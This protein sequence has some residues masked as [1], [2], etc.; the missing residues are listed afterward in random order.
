MRKIIAFI[1]LMSFYSFAF[2]QAPDVIDMKKFTINGISKNSS[3]NDLVTIFGKPDSIFDPKYDCGPLS[4]HW[5][6]VEVY[7]YS[8][9]NIE[10]HIIN[11]RIEFKEIELEKS[12]IQFEIKIEDISINQNST[13]SDLK[14]YFPNS[15]E[16]YLEKESNIFRLCPCDYCD[17]EI[18]F[19]IN[20]NDKIQKI[21]YH[22]P[23]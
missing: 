5:N 11:G 22:H 4:P 3:I 12:V 9:S 20:E 23:C 13:I 1:T 21:K 7:L 8:Y 6:N 17:S 15:C 18:W 16:S 19:F 10:F 2:G 14:R